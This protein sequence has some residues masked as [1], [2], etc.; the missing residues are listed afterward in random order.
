M[1]SLNQWIWVWVNSGSWWWTGRPDVLQFMGSQRVR[2]NWANELNWWFPS[3]HVWLWELDWKENEASKNW[4]LRTIM[5]DNP[6]KITWTA[7][8]SNQSILRDINPE[9]SLE[10]LMLTLKLLYFGHLIQTAL[11][12]EKFL[13]LG[14]IEGRRKRWHLGMRWLDGTTN[15]M[16]ISL[17]KLLEMVRD[18]EAWCATVHVVTKS[19]TWLAPEQ[20]LSYVSFSNIFSSTVVYS[21]SFGKVF[22]RAN[23]FIFN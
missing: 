17:G 10:G 6:W 8:R 3:G 22:H 15:A 13:M 20:H 18:R 5:L 19:Q 9:Y 7:I 11:S 4:C 1:V 12:L 2:H 14:K 23:A 16:D 21:N